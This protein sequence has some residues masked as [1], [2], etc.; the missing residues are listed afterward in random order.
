MDAGEREREREREREWQDEYTIHSTYVQPPEGNM[1]GSQLCNVPKSGESNRDISP[2]RDSHTF[3]GGENSIDTFFLL[4]VV[5]A[6][7]SHMNPEGEPLVC[8]DM[9][10]RGMI[11]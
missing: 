9:I 10:S 4:C 1:G 7:Q 3:M 6:S 8:Y 5:M 11:S 2:S